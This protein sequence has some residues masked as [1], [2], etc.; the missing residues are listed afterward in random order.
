MRKV[1]AQNNGSGNGTA[2]A[3]AGSAQSPA[4][5]QDSVNSVGKSD[6]PI[7]KLP[8]PPCYR[9]ELAPLLAHSV[10]PAV[11]IPLDNGYRRKAHLATIFLCAISLSLCG[12]AQYAKTGPWAPNGVNYTLSRDRNTGELTDYFGVSWQLK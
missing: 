11:W 2:M 4:A 9:R 7:V 5:I 6:F 12:C 10:N 8:D 1:H 3:A